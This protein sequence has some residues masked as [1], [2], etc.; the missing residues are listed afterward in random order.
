MNNLDNDF[1][2]LYS[3]KLNLLAIKQCS[4]VHNDFVYSHY[5]ETSHGQTTIIDRRNKLFEACLDKVY[6]LHKIY[7]EELFK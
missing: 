5:Y 6:A 7:D 1:N 2:Q 3:D 4:K